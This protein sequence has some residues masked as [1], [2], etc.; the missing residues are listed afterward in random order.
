VFDELNIRGSTTRGLE[1]FHRLGI[2]WEV[3]AVSALALAA[4]LIPAHSGVGGR[5]VLNID[6]AWIRVF[7]SPGGRS[8]A[9]EISR[10]SHVG[11]R[12]RLCQ[13]SACA[14]LSL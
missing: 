12:T 6:R 2:D 10:E 11:G 3:A 14:G 13:R 7:L 1:I 4:V 9:C 5:F 8:S